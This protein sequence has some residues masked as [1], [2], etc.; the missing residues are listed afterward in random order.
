M[1]FHDEP[2]V[3]KNLLLILIKYSTVNGLCTVIHWGRG[4]YSDQLF[5]F[6][7]E[8]HSCSVPEC[9]LTRDRGAAGS[10]LTGVTVLC[11]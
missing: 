5:E 11:P 2:E 10:S 6:E 7:M 3:N 8:E 4:S 1:L 9:K